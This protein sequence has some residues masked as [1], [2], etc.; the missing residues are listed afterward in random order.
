MAAKTGASFAR[1][2]NRPRSKPVVLAAGGVMWRYV[3]GEL[4][5]LLVH[6]EKFRDWSFPKGKVDPGETLPE[7]AVREL[8]EETGIRGILGPSLGDVQYHLPSGR[9]KL[10]RYWAVE[11]TPEAVSASTF[12]PNKEIAALEWLTIDAARQELSY[13]VD[14]DVLRAFEQLVAVDGLGTFA[15]ALMRHGQ[16]VPGSS[17][18][19]PDSARPLTP[20]GTEQARA[21]V[22]PL[23]AFG[24]QKVVTSTAV[25]CQ[26][27]VLP[28]SQKLGRRAYAVDALSQAT[29]ETGDDDVAPVV[30]KRIRKEK[31]AVICSHSPVL[32]AIMEAVAQATGTPSSRE[33]RN[34]SSLRTGSFT[35][36]H[37]RRGRNDEGVVAIETHSPLDERAPAK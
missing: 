15:I 18:D 21:A 10:V 25:R 34:A 27:T 29:W 14:H 3:E 31:G 2:R 11:A 1:A 17:I 36:V 16:A 32:P 26:E 24:I 20:R 7:T 30:D 6:R 33:L 37:V 19:G 5:V 4:Q 13:P 35:I 23:R 22:S 28:L 8:E 12:R 9:E